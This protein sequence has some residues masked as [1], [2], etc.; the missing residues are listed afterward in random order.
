MNK[1]V[2]RAVI[3]V[4]FIIILSSAQRI[5]KLCNLL[6]GKSLSFTRGARTMGTGLRVFGFFIDQAACD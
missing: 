2:W 3:E 5:R 1:N 4:G 6:S